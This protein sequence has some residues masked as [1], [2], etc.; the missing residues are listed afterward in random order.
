MGVGLKNFVVAN[1]NILICFLFFFILGIS[2]S[3]CMWEVLDLSRNVLKIVA[4]N[5]LNHVCIGGILHLL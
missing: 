3:Y 2:S 4:I 5:C 1:T